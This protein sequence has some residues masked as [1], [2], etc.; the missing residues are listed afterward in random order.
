MKKFRILITLCLTV[1]TL[2]VGISA[3]ENLFVL[4]WSDLLTA[5]EESALNA[6]L[7]GISDEADANIIVATVDSLEGDSAQNFADNLYDAGL[8]YFGLMD[9]TEDG[10]LL[11][12]AM[13]ERQWAISTAGYGIEDENGEPE[14][15]EAETE[16][17]FDF[18]VALDS[19]S[20][21]FD[22]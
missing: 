1:L 14:V 3:E 13:N 9:G 2:T 10:A 6:F 18:D 7:G 11:L 20:G 17:V 8:T 16:D 4:D 12:V 22:E 19:L 15:A 5:E 21:D